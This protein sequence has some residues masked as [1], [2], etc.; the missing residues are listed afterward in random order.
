MSLIH[1]YWGV[2]KAPVGF[3]ERNCTEKDCGESVVYHARQMTFL[4][5]EGTRMCICC[6]TVF[7]RRGHVQ[8]DRN[9][10]V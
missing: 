6:G 1:H 3:D 4:T 10:N 5:A 7:W 9:W 8:R 2:P